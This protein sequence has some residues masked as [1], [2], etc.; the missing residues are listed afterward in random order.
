MGQGRPSESH[1]TPLLRLRRPL[2]CFHQ[3]KLG[4]SRQSI[5]RS[6]TGHT[7]ARRLDIL[8][9]MGSWTRWTF[10]LCLLWLTQAAHGNHFH[11]ERERHG[12]EHYYYDLESESETVGRDMDKEEQGHGHGQEVDKAGYEHVHDHGAS[13][14][15]EFPLDEEPIR[16]GDEDEEAP[17]H[18]VT[19]IDPASPAISL[20]A[21]PGFNGAELFF[22]G[23][24]LS[25]P[26]PFTAKSHRFKGGVNWTIYPGTNYTGNPIC[27]V[28]DPRHHVTLNANHQVQV[29]SV[30]RGCWCNESMMGKHQFPER[31]SILRF[32]NVR[33]NW[34]PG[35]RN[36]F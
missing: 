21:E 19:D 28:A 34:K 22:D 2:V 32:K 23:S 20:T 4:G 36:C 13:G 14:G 17:L 7:T 9:R 16:S 27:L 15:H 11:Q 10:T 12:H 31:S 6:L 33:V 30:R 8:G 24:G 35:N 1:F 29:G 26:R 18:L 25:L 3:N 5:G